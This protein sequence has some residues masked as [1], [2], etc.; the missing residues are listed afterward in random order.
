MALRHRAASPRRPRRGIHARGGVVPPTLEGPPLGDPPG[1]PPLAVPRRPLVPRRPGREDSDPRLGAADRRPQHCRARS[2]AFCSDPPSRAV[3]APQP[4]APASS[5]R[6]GAATPTR[7]TP[8]RARL[9]PR[10]GRPRPAPP[11]RRP[12]RADPPR[13]R[14]RPI[15]R[16]RGSHAPARSDR[17]PPPGRPRPQ[18]PETQPRGDRST[19]RGPSGISILKNS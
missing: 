2:S 5:S 9:S 11:P 10:P 15:G 4:A 17:P 7:S 19:H 12:A 13:T 1:C 6:I 3:A 16:G 8:T 18:R 14:F